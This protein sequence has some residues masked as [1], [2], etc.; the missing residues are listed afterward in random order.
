MQEALKMVDLEDDSKQTAGNRLLR[1]LDQ[2]SLNPFIYKDKE[3]DHFEPI[4]CYK[5]ESKING[6]E[7]TILK[8][9]ISSNNTQLKKCH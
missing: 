1:Y 4:I 8:E 5:G 2:K 3:V 9:L 6:Y 7:A